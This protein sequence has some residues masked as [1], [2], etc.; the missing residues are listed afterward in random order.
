MIN[1]FSGRIRV[2]EAQLNKLKTL[3]TSSSSSLGTSTV[4]ITIPFQII[5]T[6]TVS[7]EVLECYSSKYANIN[8]KT[9]DGSPAL[10][11]VEFI[12]P[13]NF[14]NRRIITWDWISEE[15]SYQYNHR[16]CIEG[17]EEDLAALNRGQTLPVVNW[18][19]RIK[20]TSLFSYYIKYEDYDI[21]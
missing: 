2:I 8:L 12:S 3:G 21:T 11:S 15:T 6:R 14:G 16:I 13:L 4:D 7:G 20:M 9:N 10:F 5:A 19:F 1:T 18:K 17:N